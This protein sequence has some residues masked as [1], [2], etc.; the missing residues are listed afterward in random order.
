MNLYGG[1]KVLRVKLTP[2]EKS[3]V[4]DEPLHGHGMNL[5]PVIV[6]L[7]GLILLQVY[8]YLHNEG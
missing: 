7:P 8:D 1:C 6:F 4:Y 5:Y 2:G 3:L